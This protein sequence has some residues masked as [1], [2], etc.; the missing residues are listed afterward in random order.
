LTDCG[1]AGSRHHK[2]SHGNSNRRTCRCCSWQGNNKSISK[3]KGCF[4]DSDKCSVFNECDEYEDEEFDIVRPTWTTCIGQ[5]PVP[6][7]TIELY[8][9][10]L[11]DF[12]TDKLF[13]KTSRT[14]P[15]SENENVSKVEASSNDEDEDDGICDDWEI[16]SVESVISL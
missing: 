10:M 6:P 9:K 12:I 11:S 14:L 4:K 3:Q 2:K 8:D 15:P 1:C 7:N 13:V 16:V 5:L